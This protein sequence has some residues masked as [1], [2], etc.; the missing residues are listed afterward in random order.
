MC[1]VSKNVLRS[2]HHLITVCFS[3]VVKSN[4]NPPEKETGGWI[5]G[6]GAQIGTEE[7]RRR[8]PS[9]APYH[10]FSWSFFENVNNVFDCDGR[11]FKLEASP[12]I[13][14]SW[15]Y[16]EL[17]R[18]F[19]V[20]LET[21]FSHLCGQNTRDLLHSDHGLVR[22]KATLEISAVGQVTQSNQ[23]TYKKIL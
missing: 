21:F 7:R 14:M 22:G 17:F 11:N 5:W 12:G 1:G 20:V 10:V 8:A 13:G 3:A 15:K 16:G 23:G 18:Q 9:R 19:V 2:F 4:F 6:R